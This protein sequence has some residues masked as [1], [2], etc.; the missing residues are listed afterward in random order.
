MAITL[1]ELAGADPALVFS[2]Y[3]WRTRLALA[4]KGLDVETVPWCFTETD[5]LAFSG[6]GKVPVIVD[7]AKATHDSWAIAEYLDAAYPDRPS[8]LGGQAG[9]AH[10]RF[11]NAWTDGV[12]L[13][14][15]ARLVVRDILD[16][17]R[18]QDQ[19]YFRTSRE[20]A[21]GMT[22]EQVQE[23]REARVVEWRRALAPAR[24]VL[25]AQPWLGGAVPDYADYILAGSLMWPRCVSRFQLLEDDDAMALWFARVRGLFG[26][27]AEAART[28]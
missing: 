6:Q 24:T 10:A 13:P 20:R 14:G 19:P 7:G 16:V 11:I 21:F 8:L 4:H 3:C 23:G 25:K 27:M 1:Y 2:P 12:V 15:I 5:K 18:P 9:A 17:L 28:A 22:L 26:G